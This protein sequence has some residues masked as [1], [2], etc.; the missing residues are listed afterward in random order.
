MKKHRIL[1]VPDFSD[2]QAAQRAFELARSLVGR[3][4]VYYQVYSQNGSTFLGDIRS[5]LRHLFGC[6]ARGRFGEVRVVCCPPAIQS[7]LR[8]ARQ[9][10]RRFIR[11]AVESYGIDTIINCSC[12]RHPVRNRN[13]VFYV[14]DVTGRQL[15]SRV[16]GVTERC[17]RLIAQ[18]VEKADFIT[19]DSRDLAREIK[20]SF[21]T[22]PYYVVNGTDLESLREAGRDTVKSLRSE[23]KLIGKRVLG[24]VG[25]VSRRSNVDFVVRSFVKYAESRPNVILLVVGGGDALLGLQ[26]EFGKHPALRLVGKVPPQ[27]IA[28]YMH[29]L[30]IGIIPYGA[31]HADEL[32]VVHRIL[33][34]GACRKNV[35]S[36][37]LIEVKRMN[38]P[39]IVFADRTEEAWQAGLDLVLRKRFRRKWD[40]LF[41]AHDWRFIVS[42]FTEAMEAK[43]WDTAKACEN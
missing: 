8:W 41:D 33:Q 17:R 37:P 29:L 21:G 39:N 31:E 18:E 24:Y 14:C 2:T 25:E 1:V 7:S 43:G 32:G 5:G 19:C 9:I 35:I 40:R 16:G 4:E 11:H 22:A 34:Y 13:G 27:D 3:H 42:K 23:L 26:E 12:L 36:T 38:L 30:R 6:P 15:G 28:P 20:E 10:N